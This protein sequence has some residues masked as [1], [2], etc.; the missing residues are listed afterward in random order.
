MQKKLI[1]LGLMLTPFVVWAGME[2]R[3]AKEVAAIAI[4]LALGLFALYSGTLKKFR[5]YWILAFVGF[6]LVSMFFAPQFGF[7][8]S[9]REG[10]KITLLS[11]R[12]ISGVWAFKPFAYALIYLLMLIAISSESFTFKELKKTLTVM[13]FAGFIMS[14]Y[15]YI[16]AA[17]L[18]QFF[19]LQD[20]N[21]ARNATKGL[22]GGFIGQPTT[23]APFIAMLVPIALYLKR[24]FFTLCMI[25]A[26]FMIQSDV[27]IAGMIIGTL[28]YMCISGRKVNR[29]IGISVII[30]TLVAGV[31]GTHRYKDFNIQKFMTSRANGR[32]SAWKIM[33]EDYIGP[34]K[35][36][37]ATV[38]GFGPGAFKYT[39]SIRKNNNW[40]EAHSEPLELLYN[41]GIVG[42]SLF[43]LALWKMI[44]LVCEK[45]SFHYIDEYVLSLLG[46]LLGILVC[47]LG[48]FP[49]HIAPTMFYTVVILG[50]I[51]NENILGGTTL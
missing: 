12:S 33:Y 47:S 9:F 37:K 42:L 2:M 24:Y 8:L 50:L 29:V 22:L 31:Y 41:F 27:A 20:T 35:G 38:T 14:L 18:D 21:Q 23:C 44:S 25:I 45:L 16:Q 15:I 36:K 3:T 1:N 30:L 34:I 11:N 28:G 49:F 5:N 6:F 17:G 51:H 13:V 10:M 43:I 32:F 39:H 48:S 19:A 4:A 7:L 46:G 40:Q 26:V